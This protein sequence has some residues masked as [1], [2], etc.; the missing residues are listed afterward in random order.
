[1]DAGTDCLLRRTE[2]YSSCPY[3]A[4]Q[5][6]L[7]GG[8]HCKAGVCPSFPEHP[9]QVLRSLASQWHVGP[10]IPLCTPWQIR[11]SRLM[12]SRATALKGRCTHTAWLRQLPH[13]APPPIHG[14][15]PRLSCT[16]CPTPK[17]PLHAGQSVEP[18]LH[19]TG[20]LPLKGCAAPQRH[21]APA[22][23][24]VMQAHQLPRRN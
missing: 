11:A 1:M 23:T 8:D 17:G 3:K 5:R 16:W 20:G 14:V 13:G 10:R 7:L 21:P 15:P 12:G 4:E 6:Y 18:T 2:P 22:N 24:T 9:Y 19:H